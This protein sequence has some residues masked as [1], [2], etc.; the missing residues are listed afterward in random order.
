MDDCLGSSDANLRQRNP[1]F[2]GAEIGPS[3]PRISHALQTNPLRGSLHVHPL[4]S[5]LRGNPLVP[6]LPKRTRNPFPAHAAL[7]TAAS[8]PV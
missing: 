6:S 3:E 8:A 7:D 5:C 2:D 1:F 4:K